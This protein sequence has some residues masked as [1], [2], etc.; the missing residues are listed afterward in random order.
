MYPSGARIAKE[1]L[2][3]PLELACSGYLFSAPCCADACYYEEVGSRKQEVDWVDI[4]V[5]LGSD[6]EEYREDC[7]LVLRFL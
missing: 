6:L 3:W 2:W 5:C 4:L 7:A 1:I